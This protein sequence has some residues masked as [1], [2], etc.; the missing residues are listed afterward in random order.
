MAK[1]KTELAQDLAQ[2][3]GITTDPER[4]TASVLEEAIAAET[5]DDAQAVLDLADEEREKAEAEAAKKAQASGATPKKGI[6]RAYLHPDSTV[7]GLMVEG[8]THSITRT[9]GVP[10]SRAEFDRHRKTYRL[11]SHEERQKRLEAE[12]KKAEEEG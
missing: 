5:A 11:E 4:F 12:A 3:H 7:G 1:T 10:I 2:K 8:A 9:R 6:V